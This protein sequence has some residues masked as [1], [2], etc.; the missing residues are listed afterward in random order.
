MEKI[1]LISRVR[2]GD[3]KAFDE[4]C[5]K[6]YAMLVSYAR[7]FL[8][9]DWAEDVVQDVFYNVWQRRETLDDSNS[10]YKYL[11]RSVYNR[12][13]NYLDKNR[14]AGEYGAYYRERIAALGSSYY[15]P[16]NSPVVQKLY[17]DD[18]RASLDAAIESLPPKCREVFRLSYIEDLSNREIGEQL[19]ISPRTVENHMY[20]A[21][22]QLRRKLS[23][24]QLLLLLS[25]LF[26]RGV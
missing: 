10:L 21:L 7:L 2:A 19:G 15:A 23:K 22:K 14:R 25:L 18:L 8:K 9:D 6:Y 11:L 20:A 5:R 13:L 26:M 1:S 4:L 24:E 17:N 16:D 12:S 3:R